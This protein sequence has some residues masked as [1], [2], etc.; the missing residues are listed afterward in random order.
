MRLAEVFLRLGCALVAWMLLYAHAVWLA[1]LGRIGCGPEGDE[2]HMVLL[3]LVPFVIASAFLLRMTRPF[4][5]IDSILRWLGVPWA[6]LASVGAY[7]TWPIARAVYISG[8][9]ICSDTGAP[10]WHMIW[11]P[12]QLLGMGIAAAMI[13]RMWQNVSADK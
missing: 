10:G 2:L 8:R 9:A 13:I 3:W 7:H 1:A 5:E 12:A 11:V 4:P 6:V